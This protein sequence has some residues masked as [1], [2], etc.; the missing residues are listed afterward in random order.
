MQ[1]ASKNYMLNLGKQSAHLIRMCNLHIIEVNKH[2]KKPKYFC[3]KIKS[4][5]KSGENVIPRLLA[6]PL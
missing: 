5:F 4:K 1:N 2:K 3:F 6:K